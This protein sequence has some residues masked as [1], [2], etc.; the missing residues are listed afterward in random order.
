MLLTFNEFAY[1]YIMIQCVATTC[2]HLSFR[3]IWA[4][5]SVP[6][7]VTF[8]VTPK[9]LS[10]ETSQLEREPNADEQ[11][12]QDRKRCVPCFTLL[13]VSCSHFVYHTF[14]LVTH[15]YFS[16]YQHYTSKNERRKEKQEGEYEI[17]YKRIRY[18]DFFF[19]NSKK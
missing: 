4:G 7:F 1:Q 16:G 5:I 19:H 2:Q 8:C 15:L 3:L 10:Q 11:E 13:V 12:E 17:N 6:F 18:C 9:L 14:T